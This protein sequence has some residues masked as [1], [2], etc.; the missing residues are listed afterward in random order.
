MTALFYLLS[1]SYLH[2]DFG[3][4]IPY[5]LVDYNILPTYFVVLSRM[6]FLPY[7]EPY[8]KKGT[9]NNIVKTLVTDGY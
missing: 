5:F 8:Y 3:L 9:V 4:I 2:L 6:T 1:G 7:Y